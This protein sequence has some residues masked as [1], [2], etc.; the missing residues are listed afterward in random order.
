[1]CAPVFSFLAVLGKAT[2]WQDVWYCDF[3]DPSPAFY[4]F[5]HFL[6]CQKRGL[7]EILLKSKQPWGRSQKV[8]LPSIWPKGNTKIW[9]WHCPAEDGLR[10]SKV[11]DFSHCA[12]SFFVW[13]WSAAF[14][15]SWWLELGQDCRAKQ[16]MGRG[17][18]E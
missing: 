9:T 1:M 4:M 17:T 10:V 13:E 16:E 15:K 6:P 18:V 2:W 7:S 11:C 12:N 14:E 8:T 3:Y 5:C